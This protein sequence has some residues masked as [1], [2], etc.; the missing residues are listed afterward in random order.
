MAYYEICDKINK[1]GWTVKYNDNMKSP[2]VYGDGQ[3][4]GY[5]NKQSLAHRCNIINK[6][7]FTLIGIKKLYP[8]P[9]VDIVRPLVTF[10]FTVKIEFYILAKLRWCYVLGYCSR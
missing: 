6:V 4:C 1:K 2:F 10:E 5:E 3:W 8:W 9:S 7:S